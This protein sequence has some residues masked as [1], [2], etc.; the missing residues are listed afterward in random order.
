M[1]DVVVVEEEH[2][3]FIQ[4]NGAWL[5]SMLAVLLSCVAAILGYLLRSRCYLIKCCGVECRR[6]VLDLGREGLD[7]GERQTA[8]SNV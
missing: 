2:F 4:R 6:D 8:H 3:D 1:S 7:M 5:L